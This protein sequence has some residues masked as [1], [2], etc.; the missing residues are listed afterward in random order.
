MSDAFAIEPTPRLT[1]E[2][3]RL[4]STGSAPPIARGFDPDAD[5]APETAIVVADHFCD[6]IARQIECGGRLRAEPLKRAR[7]ASARDRVA[8]AEAL[9]LATLPRRADEALLA[10]ALGIDRRALHEAFLSVRGR[11]LYRSLLVLRLVA[12]RRTLERYPD[13]PPA[14]VARGCG[15]ASYGRFKKDHRA[16]FGLEAR[17]PADLSRGEISRDL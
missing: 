9:V 12:V 7:V 5:V 4:A 10:A 15:F 16:E 14:S 3:P 11:S 13:L 1:D 2:G 6:R 8:A 17:A